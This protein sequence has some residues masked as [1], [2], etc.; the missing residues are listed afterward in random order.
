MTVWMVVEDEPD[1]YEMVLAMYETLGID[2]VAFTTGEEAITW[3]D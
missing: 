3:I 1:V 2:G